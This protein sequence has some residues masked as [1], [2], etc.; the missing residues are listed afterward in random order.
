MNIQKILLTPFFMLFAK[1][2]PMA[3]AKY[4]GVTMT[5]KVKIYGSSYDMD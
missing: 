4:I 1:L 3:Y 5:G 2:K